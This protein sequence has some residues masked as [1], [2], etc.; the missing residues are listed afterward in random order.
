MR[1]SRNIFIGFLAVV[2]IV[3]GVIF[4]PKS[5][6]AEEKKDDTTGIVYVKD[7]VKYNIKNFWS[8]KKVPMKDGYIFAGWYSEATEGKY[9]TEETAASATE[10]WAKF[11]PDYVLSVR[12]Q[13]EDGTSATD[14]KASSTR[15][16]SSVDSA[17][18]KNVGFDIWLANKTQLTMSDGN[19]PLITTKAFKNILVND[20][21]VS[22]TTTFGVA[23]KYY[24]VWRLDNIANE[25]DGKIIY[26]R[27]YWITMDGTKVEGLAKY[28]HVEDEYKGYVN[29]PIN[30][31]TGEAIAAGV[32]K[33]EYKD[34]LTFVGFEEGRLLK[35]MEVNYGV[36]GVISMVGNA[37][38]AN[39]AIYANGIY[40][41]LRFQKTGT[42]DPNSLITTPDDAADF[43]NWDEGD[44]LLSPVIQY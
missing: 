18:Y 22:A 28:M 13:N 3:A 44:V 6:A 7:S 30:L 32:V 1:K 27:P 34:G 40:A 15:V 36:D 9:L 17:D 10:A 21:P 12:A 2:V 24:V 42:T 20:E 4:V 16:L 31:M 37:E 38:T 11:V 43:S 8:E 25:N 19:A 23:S 14:N 39:Q 29:V 5:V 41:N 33:M 26:V 35:E